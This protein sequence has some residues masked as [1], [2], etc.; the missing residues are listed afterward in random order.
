MVL[1]EGTQCLLGDVGQ[2]RDAGCGHVEGD[3]HSP[4]GSSDREQ[5]AG[6]DSGPD[7]LGR[8]NVSPG[9]AFREVEGHPDTPVVQQPQA[10][11]S[12]TLARHLRVRLRDEQS[13]VVDEPCTA[14]RRQSAQGGGLVVHL[15]EFVGGDVVGGESACRGCVRR[16]L[17]DPESAHAPE[18]GC[19]GPQR[20]LDQ[21]GPQRRVAA[22]KVVPRGEGEAEQLPITGS[23][24]RHPVAAQV[25]TAPADRQPWHLVDRHGL[26]E[27]LVDHVRVGD[28]AIDEDVQI[29]RHCV[30]LDEDVTCCERCQGRD[31]PEPVGDGFGPDRTGARDGVRE[32]IEHRLVRPPCHFAVPCWHGHGPTG[33]CPDANF[34]PSA[35]SNA[36]ADWGGVWSW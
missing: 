2:A 20:E 26:V 18:R 35:S 32:R 3:D 8:A 23:R 17:G 31:R 19:G 9:I 24:R 25:E 12:L 28:A 22:A 36:A 6:A 13:R 16:L 11:T 7:G 10:V 34:S 33:S 21:R 4:G 29:G 15:P 1:V 27:V 5:G 30:L 14:C